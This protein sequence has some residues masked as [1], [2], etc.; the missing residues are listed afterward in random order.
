VGQEVK[1][2]QVIGYLGSTGH[3]TG[4]HVHYEVRI[5]GVPVNP[6]PVYLPPFD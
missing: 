5:H 4:S 1:R 6:E 3:S 2:G